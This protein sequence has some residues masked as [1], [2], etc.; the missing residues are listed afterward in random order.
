[1]SINVSNLEVDNRDYLSILQDLID[2][3]PTLTDKWET[4]DESDPGIA[5]V[6]LMSMYG[7]MLSYNHDK[8]VLEV[9]PDTVTQRKNA[10]Q[11]FGLIGYKMRWYQSSRC[12]AYLV[13]TNLK[14]ATLPRYS[15]FSTDDN[16]V[17]YTYVGDA[18]TG[19][20]N[21]DSSSDPTATKKSYEVE[22]VQG[23]PVKPTLV[24]D[25][26][27]PYNQNKEW[28]FAYNY[29]I[30]K[31]DIIEDNRIYLWDT[32][33][34][35]FSVTLVGNGNE[36]TQVE[37]IDVL[38]S[39][40]QFY[41]FKVD[42]DDRPYLKLVSYWKDYN[43]SGNFKVFYLL[44]AGVDGQI[45]VNALTHATSK[46]PI[47][48]VATDT[49]SDVSADILITNNQSTFGYGPETPQE[50]RVEAA[51]YIN[52]HD[53]LITLEDFTRAVKRLYGV[54]NC[55]CTDKTNDPNPED[56]TSL[57]LNI[58]IAE[59]DD[60][61]EAVLPEVYKNYV[62]NALLENKMIYLETNV[63]LDGITYY[64]WNLIGKIYTKEL[65]S[66]DRAQDIIIRINNKLRQTYALENMEFN[67]VINYVDIIDLI[68]AADPLVKN[69]YLQPVE[70]I[71]ENTNELSTE[72]EITGKYTAYSTFTDHE[73]KIIKTFYMNED[74]ELIDANDNI[75]PYVYCE[76]NGNMYQMHLTE[77]VIEDQSKWVLANLDNDIF[78]DVLD[79]EK[80][81]KFVAIDGNFDISTH[82]Y[83]HDNNFYEDIEFT[84]LISPVANAY[85]TNLFDDEVYQYSNGSYVIQEYKGVRYIQNTIIL[86]DR[87]G[88]LITVKTPIYPGKFSIRIDS[89]LHTIYDN[90]NGEFDSDSGIFDNGKINY[91]TGDFYIELIRD[92]NNITLIYNRNVINMAKFKSLDV[93]RF[94][95]ADECIKR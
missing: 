36:W 22:L 72:E 37:N 19:W 57:D 66:E 41:E 60:Y 17:T 50:A 5:L 89:S 7:D 12:N 42:E 39:S 27:I 31:Q 33:V 88:E 34:D 48:D 2:T 18:N 80:P 86:N 62:S 13:N 56:L 73:S 45:A 14:T 10:A 90:K 68:L 24:N 9:Y 63:I 65:V 51:K 93:L 40:G 59:T 44:S 61:A 78:I 71:N 92:I 25:L 67:N 11:I 6:K 75:L 84:H 47:Y 3:I 26:L 76:F 85:Y 87:H 91:Q 53:T 15:T 70:Y 64:I 82:G 23:I 94:Y 58:Y 20:L 30:T 1:M 77:I 69:V 4:N 38:T 32:N 83:Y 79:G 81:I 29:N 21:L 16:K 49:E 43:P 95:V 54:A 52:T 74:N 46:V 8:A 28:H 35:E 55:Y